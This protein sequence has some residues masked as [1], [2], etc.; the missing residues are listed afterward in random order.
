MCTTTTSTCGQKPRVF[1]KRRFGEPVILR[2]PDVPGYPDYLL[3]NE[4][5]IEYLKKRIAVTRKKIEEQN[6]RKAIGG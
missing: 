6:S 4:E 1:Q 2:N 3:S 5:E